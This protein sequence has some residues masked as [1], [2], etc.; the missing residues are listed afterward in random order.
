MAK[1]GKPF[2]GVWHKDRFR[3]Y[4]YRIIDIND[5]V[6]YIGKGSNNRLKVQMR[7]FKKR[8]EEIAFFKKETEAYKFEREM[9][10]F[11]QPSLNR[12]PGGN[13][14]VVTKKVFR[15]CRTKTEKLWDKCFEELGSRVYTARYI[16]IN[17]SAF[18][19][20][21]VTIASK[22]EEIEQ[23]RQIAYGSR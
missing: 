17:L 18:R 12:H 19:K 23:L 10:K 5:I 1:N 6:V 2:I 20:A 13:G 15:D 7:S 11:Y 9:I 4:V 21:G 22:V 16:L 14:S 3:F 8:G